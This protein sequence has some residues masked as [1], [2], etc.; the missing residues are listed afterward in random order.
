MSA[1]HSLILGI[2]Q[3][4]S[5]FLPVSSSG[6]LLLTSYI[7]GISSPPIIF[8][9]ILHL[10]TVLSLLVFL[11]KEIVYAFKNIRLILLL[12]TSVVFTGVTY[13]PFKKLFEESYETVN[14]LPFFFLFTAIYLTLF[15][16]RRGGGKKAEEISFFSAI[17]LGVLQGIAI[18]P[19]I[20]RSGM[21]L[22]GGVLI[23]LKEEESFKYTFL[24]AIPSIII[25]ALYKF[26]EYIKVPVHLPL[27]PL[28]L[29]FLSSFIFGL[30]SLYIL[31]RFVKKR[32]MLV[33]S[34]YLFLVSLL[35]F[36][37]LK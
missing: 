23:G 25:A 15:Y 20:S 8:D 18:F 27:S 19:G 35:T 33:F 3:G 29:G 24:L 16:L 6:H 1:L 9:L 11:K 30:I 7:L 31:L 22:V 26:Y 13:F 21:V 4:L 10:G 37:I 14:Y 32:E 12:M 34:I 36:F 17:L 2:V 5:E 28:F